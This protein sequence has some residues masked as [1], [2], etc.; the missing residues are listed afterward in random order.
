[1]CAAARVSG[2]AN[3]AAPAAPLAAARWGNRGTKRRRGARR[4]RGPGAEA[5]GC[6]RPPARPVVPKKPPGSPGSPHVLPPGHGHQ[7]PR[8][9]Q[10]GG[11]LQVGALG[12]LWAGK[13]PPGGPPWLLGT[14]WCWEFPGFLGIP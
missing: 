12:G 4:E 1:M 9:A 3:A 8:G 2:I 14:C 10:A 6:P 5:P 11:C 7:R 13:P